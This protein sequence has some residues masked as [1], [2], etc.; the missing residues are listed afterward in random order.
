MGLKPKRDGLTDPAQR[1]EAEVELNALMAQ[2]YG[3]GR[4]EFQFLMDLLFMTPDYRETHTLMRNDI[5][6]RL[7]E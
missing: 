4:K 2:L 7:K 3:L 1:R 6:A 5:S